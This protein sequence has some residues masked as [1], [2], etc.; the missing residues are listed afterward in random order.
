MNEW[1]RNAVAADIRRW[2]VNQEPP[3]DRLGY[4]WWR[5]WLLRQ[6]EKTQRNYP[7]DVS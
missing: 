2:R 6:V 5:R 1:T 4:V 3:G 7:K